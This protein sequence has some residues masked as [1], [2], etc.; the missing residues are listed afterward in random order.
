METINISV[1]ATIFNEATTIIQLL[2]SLRDQTYP[3]TEIILVDAGST[4]GTK[5]LIESY[6]MDNPHLPVKFVEKIGLNRSEGRNEGISMT[7]NKYVAVIDGGC[8]ADKNWLKYL[9]YGFK[10]D[11][12]V[13]VVA[14][15]YQVSPTNY[16]QEGFAPY[17]AVMPD[18]LETTTFL[19]SSRSLAMTKNAWLK[20]GKYPENLET[21][22]DMVF[23]KKL[24]GGSQMVVEPKAWVTWR[25]PNSLEEFFVTVVGYARGDVEAGYYPHLIKMATL[26]VRYFIFGLVPILFLVYLL[27]PMIRHGKYMSKT[28][29]VWVLSLIQ[30]TSDLA[31]ICGLFWGIYRR[32]QVFGRSFQH[33]GHN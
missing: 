5:R 11:R 7:T 19:P 25:L 17:L 33:S 14:G 10:L 23:A 26:W 21:C 24:A 3:P 6:T 9:V 31:V 20:A 15:Y 30:L 28:K 18:R 29:D 13:E 4:D 32:I 2:D 22:E 8:R 12:Q 16:W 1:V 27:Y